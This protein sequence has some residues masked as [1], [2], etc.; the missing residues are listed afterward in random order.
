[1]KTSNKLLISLGIIFF[2][3][4]LLGMMII[5]KIYYKTADNERSFNE[6]DQTFKT[7]SEKTAILIDKPYHAVN[8]VNG[9][10]SSIELHLHQEENSGVKIQKDLVENL[11]FK[12]ENGI[13]NITLKN[14]FSVPGFGE[15]MVIFAYSPRVDSLSVINT[16]NFNLV[17]VADSLDINLKGCNSFSIGGNSLME[18]YEIING[19]TINHKI[20]D[21]TIVKKLNVDLDESKFLMSDLNIE[22]LAI[23]AQ[24]H[25]SIELNGNSQNKEKS[26][27]NNLKIKTLGENTVKI[28]NFIQTNGIKADLSDETTLEIPGSILKSVVKNN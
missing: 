17:T 6:N 21:K 7:P 3:V 11:S 2:I 9:N 10:G 22:H 8:I 23:K 20:F 28:N 19:D 1:M 12:V 27:I 25:S 14:G 18:S 4:P 5:S 24:N 13:L 16:S 15:R 26:I